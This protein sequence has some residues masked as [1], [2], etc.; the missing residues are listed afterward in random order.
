VVPQ[1]HV[2]ARQV[3]TSVNHSIEADRLAPLVTDDLF[4]EHQT[5]CPQLFQD[6]YIIFDCRK[7]AKGSGL[8]EEVLQSQRQ[9]RVHRNK[10]L[11]LHRGK[12]QDQYYK[13]QVHGHESYHGSLWIR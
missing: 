5:A 4:I 7:L 12:E 13:N 2:E 1:I 10:N 6:G 3:S 9:L 8:G 11:L